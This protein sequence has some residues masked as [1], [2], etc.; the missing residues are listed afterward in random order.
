MPFTGHENHAI[1]LEEASKLTANFRKW[2]PNATKAHFFGRDSI[3]Q[4]LDQEACVGIRIYNGFDENEKPQLIMVGVDANE[5]DLYTG[6]IAEFSQPCPPYC[7]VN[8]S[9]NS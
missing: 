8:N 1:T 9:L 4:I 7:G 6:V 5:S 2:R 3:Q